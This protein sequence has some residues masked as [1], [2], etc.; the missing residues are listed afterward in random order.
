MSPTEDGPAL[1][2]ANQKSP[3]GDQRGTSTSA[4]GVSKRESHDSSGFYARFAAPLVDSTSKPAGPGTSRAINE[5]F[6]GDARDMSAVPDDSVGLVVTSPPYFAGKQYEEVLGEG[7]V[8]GSYIEYLEML[9]DVFA[10]CLRCL[11]PG[12]RI[13]VNVANL[14]RR[15][16]RSLS[17]DV[18]TILQDRLHMLLRGEIIWQK[19]KGAAGNCAWGSF[20]KPG[21]PVLRDTTERVI[22]ASKGRFDRTPSASGRRRSGLP[23]DATIGRDEFMDATLDL[24]EFPSES[25]TRVGHPAPFP[26]ALPRRLIELH[27][28]SGDLV[29][30]PFM[31][32]GTTAVA[33]VATGR[34][35]VG[36]DTE[37]EYVDAAKTRLRL[38]ESPEVVSSAAADGEPS[39]AGQ[40]TESSLSAD[41]DESAGLLERAL[42]EGY[43]ARDVAR[44]SLQ[45]AGAERILDAP[46]LPGG[47]EMSF[48]AEFEGVRW[49]VDVCG[50]FSTSRGGLNRSE[51][52]W[53]S[54]GRAAVASVASPDA[55]ILLLSTA[56][57]AP[58]PSA[59]ALES[60]VADGMV[61]IVELGTGTTVDDIRAEVRT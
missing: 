17:S 11:E 2:P 32:S 51:V 60:V 59:K 22:V 45:S 20:Q 21:N 41:A 39:A 12:G 19:Q 57:P 61:Q 25:A 46:K 9:H 13:A 6:V 36:Y 34:N 16:Y 38:L 43:S 18:A 35:Y 30:D 53:R 28:F 44:L 31:G 4:F 42:A 56:M 47:A 37:P 55:R 1:S 3:D 48:S 26:V 5:I 50:S 14:G 23:A 58:G 40:G 49:L 10:D 33:A 54:M 7:S 15:P 52:L 29:L 24:W 27:T 8:P